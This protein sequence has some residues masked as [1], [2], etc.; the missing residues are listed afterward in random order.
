MQSIS[1]KLLSIKF[2]RVK[3]KYKPKIIHQLIST[4]QTNVADI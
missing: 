4:N 3:P 1:L 2:Q